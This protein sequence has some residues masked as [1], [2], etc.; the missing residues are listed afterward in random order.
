MPPLLPPVLE[1]RQSWSGHRR[2]MWISMF[3]NP[4]DKSPY[5]LFGRRTQSG[6]KALVQL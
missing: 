3:V 1:A 2:S 6:M 5:C 4:I